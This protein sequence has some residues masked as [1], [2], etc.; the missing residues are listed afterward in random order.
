METNSL[1]VC[2][3]INYCSAFP[4]VQQ[5]VQCLILYWFVL[6]KGLS[7]RIVSGGDYESI[8]VTVSSHACCR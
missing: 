1:L 3:G 4:R 7:K 2:T 6:L 8:D 5:L